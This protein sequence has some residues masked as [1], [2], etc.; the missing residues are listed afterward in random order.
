MFASVNTTTMSRVG[1]SRFRRVV[2]YLLV[3][4]ASARSLGA[5]HLRLRW[6]SRHLLAVKADGDR[7][8]LIES[9]SATQILVSLCLALHPG[10]IDNES[11]GKKPFELV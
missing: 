7:L 5:F 10:G 2:G 11:L 3:D 6:V 4:D 8:S 1:D 9:M